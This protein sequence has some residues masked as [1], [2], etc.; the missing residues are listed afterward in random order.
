[1]NKKNKKKKPNLFLQKVAYDFTDVYFVILDF[2]GAVWHDDSP[3]Y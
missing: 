3:N 1:M 2:R